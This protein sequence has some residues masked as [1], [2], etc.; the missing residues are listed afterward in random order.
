MLI[1]SLNNRCNHVINSLLELSEP[2]I[3]KAK[4][5]QKRNFLHKKN[6]LGYNPRRF[7]RAI[8]SC[9]FLIISFKVSVSPFS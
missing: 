6:L 8:T 3:I 2:F 9:Y 5:S 1:E 7:L 4:K